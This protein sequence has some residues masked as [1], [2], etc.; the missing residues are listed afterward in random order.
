MERN[1]N[2]RPP[3]SR[4][5]TRIVDP[6]DGIFGTVL[7]DCG[8]YFSAVM[9]DDD[10]RHFGK[11]KPRRFRVVHRASPTL[12][13]SCALRW[14]AMHI[15]ESRQI[16][17]HDGFRI[18]AHIAPDDGLDPKTNGDYSEDAIA[19]WRSGDWAYVT[20]TVTASMEG[21]KLG[22][23]ALGG[24]E[25]GWFPGVSE[26]VNPLDGTGDDFCNGYGPGLIDEAVTEAKAELSRLAT[27]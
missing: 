25:L 20:V 16:G 26:R 12:R 18:D 23:A 7:R 3:L 14:S 27:R 21:V 24:C 5:G 8:S 15:I 13:P 9:D 11:A 22:R 17:E 2:N 10:V 1:P 6:R 4:Y 19:A